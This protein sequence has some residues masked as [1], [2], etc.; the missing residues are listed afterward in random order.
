MSIK[1]VLT[2]TYLEKLEAV[3]GSVIGD[4]VTLSASIH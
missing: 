2:G 4:D 1:P 3:S